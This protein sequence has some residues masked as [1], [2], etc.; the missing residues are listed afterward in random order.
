MARIVWSS[1]AHDDLKELVAFIKK[2]DSPG[3]THTFGLHIQHRVE[4]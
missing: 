2:A 1:V 3:Y 4:Q